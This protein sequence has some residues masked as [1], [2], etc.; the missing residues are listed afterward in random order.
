MRALAI[1]IVDHYRRHRRALPWR[2]TRDPYAI[3]VSEIMLQQTRVATVIPYWQRWMARFPTVGALAAAEDDTVME[4][5]A[6]L[7]YYSR[8]RNLVRGARAV[9]AAGGAMPGD[10]D[11]LRA[12]PGIG[13]YTAGAIA[14]IAYGQRAALVDGNVARVLARV[15]GIDEDVKATAG[16]RRVWAEAE[17]LMAALPADREPGELNQGLMELGATVCTPTS[18]TCLTCPLA[19]QCVAARA[20]RQAELPVLPR[21]KRPDELPAITE[22]ALWLE[23]RGKVL[24]VRRRPGGLY[25]GLW[26]LPQGA[27]AAAAA[28]A[29][30]LTLRGAAEVRGHHRQLLSHRRLE[31]TLATGAATGRARLA[32]DRYDAL[33]WIEVTRLDALGVSSA[34]AALLAHR[35]ALGKARGPG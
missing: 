30:G 9:V 15:R 18:P 3:W 14:S 8:A 27:D 31:L 25:G 17:A 26:E 29:V 19:G 13:A 16:Q 33:R 22:V 24:A 20:G 10:A 35:P 11:A 34:T 12:L 23:R 7:G 21:R 32:S 6:G 1:A 5:W 4:A 28:A 2:Q